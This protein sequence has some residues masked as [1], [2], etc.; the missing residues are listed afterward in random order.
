M[1]NILFI[2]YGN[3]CRSPMAEMIFKDLIIKNNKRYMMSCISRATSIEEIGNDIYPQAKRKLVQMGVTCESHRATQVTKSDYDKYDYIIVM[4]ERNKR[5]LLRI[6]GEDT[7]NKIHLLLEYT[8]NIKDIDDPWYSGDFDTAFN[9]IN[10]GC[11]GLFN[12]LVNL[13]DNNEI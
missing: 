9:E 5:D 10:E 7:D 11:I 1:Y 12:Y 2:C 8:D 13:G 6:I 4:E 3:I